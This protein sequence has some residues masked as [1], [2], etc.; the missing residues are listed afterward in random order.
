MPHST[1]HGRQCLLW[2]F[3]GNVGMGE[4]VNAIDD[5][6]ALKHF[7]DIGFVL[8]DARAVEDLR[9]NAEQLERFI[10]SDYAAPDARHMLIGFIA[11]DPVVRAFIE[12]CIDRVG[13]RGTPWKM[14]LSRSR[15]EARAWVSGEMDLPAGCDLDLS[16]SLFPPAA[17][18]TV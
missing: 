2:Q 3:F 18:S 13:T 10:A 15:A 11:E 8:F 17:P 16:L 9:I 14:R 7:N 1:Q 6:C 4:I 5:L 12:Q